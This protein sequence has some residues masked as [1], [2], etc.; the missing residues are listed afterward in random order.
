MQYDG[1][2]Y[3][4][5]GSAVISVGVILFV[6]GKM[7]W[8]KFLSREGR[9]SNE[10][11]SQLSE[12]IANQEERLKAVED[13]ASEE[14]R[15]RMVAEKEVSDLTLRVYKLENELRKHNIEVPS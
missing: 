13:L 2:G 6:L 12:R 9:A 15:L 4:F 5:D 8:D 7:A 11:V 14:R 3:G 10:L 1:G